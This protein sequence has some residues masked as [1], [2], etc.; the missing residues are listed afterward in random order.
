MPSNSVSMMRF[1]NVDLMGEWIVKNAL[2]ALLN[3][4]TKMH[5]ITMVAL[6]ADTITVQV[7]TFCC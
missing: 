2:I 6:H 5:A 4:S 7:A 3:I 1:S